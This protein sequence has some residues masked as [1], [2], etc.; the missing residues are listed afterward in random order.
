MPCHSSN[1]LFIKKS[2]KP[3]LVEQAA[4]MKKLKESDFC[5]ACEKRSLIDPIVRDS[6]AECSNVP[7]A[8]V[9]MCSRNGKASELMNRPPLFLKVKFSSPP[10][11]LKVD[12]DVPTCSIKV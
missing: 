8:N 1:K 11:Y 7:S 3:V 12:L 10:E 5:K 2:D 6:G 9:G 4:Y